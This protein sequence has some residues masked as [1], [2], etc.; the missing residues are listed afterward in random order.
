MLV[1]QNYSRFKAVDNQCS[2]AELGVSAWSMS[3]DADES[4]VCPICGE[5]TISLAQLNQHIDDVHVETEEPVEEPRGQHKGGARWLGIFKEEQGNSAR[6]RFNITREHWK[7]AKKGQI[8]G[9]YGCKKY[10]EANNTHCRKCGE[11]RCPAH[12]RFRRKLGPD[13]LPDPE[14]GHWS[15]VCQLCYEQQSGNHDYTGRVRDLTSLFLGFRNS[16]SDAK[17][18]VEQRLE[19]RLVRLIDGLSQLDRSSGGLWARSDI[20]KK[21]DFEL[22]VVAWENEKGVDRCRSCGQRFSYF[23]RKHH[24]RLCGLVVCGDLERECSREVALSL[25]AEKIERPELARGSMYTLRMC[26]ECRS[27]VFAHRTFLEEIHSQ[28]P[29]VLRYSAQLKRIQRQIDSQL[30][31]FEE[32]FAKLATPSKSEE[33]SVPELRKLRYDI[34]QAFTRYE[35]LVRRVKDSHI[36][37]Q[38]EDRIKHQIVARAT[39]YLQETML[40]LQALPQALLSNSGEESSL[41][42]SKDET[43]K[44]QQN[45]VILEEQAFLLD[46]QL[47]DAKNHRKFDAMGPLQQSIN[48]IQ[49][50]LRLMRSRLGSSAPT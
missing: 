17:A 16:K 45:T 8:C 26:R 31:L 29:P 12:T 40:P 24:C 4:L 7:P 43:K 28:P 49:Q 22:Q 48:E 19:S 38:A 14:H 37:T 50:E 44:L 11:A 32:S 36:E 25:L 35:M 46:K 42:I 27:A 6:E 34:L 30:P 18:L 23:L 9:V 20:A 21:R 5:T 10:V 39:N 13:A 41:P 33:I 1:F 2:A 47:E 15:R 3:Q